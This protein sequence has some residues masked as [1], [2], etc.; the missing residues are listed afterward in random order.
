MLKGSQDGKV[1]Q[2]FGAATELLGIFIPCL[3]ASLDFQGQ[4]NANILFHTEGESLPSFRSETSLFCVFAWLLG[5]YT[6]PRVSSI[7]GS[8]LEAELAK[9]K[10]FAT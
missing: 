4:L 3:E 6:L 10:H 1:W 8:C 2:E 9:S 5:S 7:I